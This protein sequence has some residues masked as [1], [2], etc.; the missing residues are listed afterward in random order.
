MLQHEGLTPLLS[1]RNLRKAYPSRSAPPSS[2][3]QV[4]VVKDVNFDVFP[5]ETLG[6]VGESGSGK[7]TIGRA[8]LMLPRPTAGSIKFGDQELT[9][10][11]GDAL[12]DTRRR[13]Q[14][15]FQDPYA[16]LNPRMTIGS[17]IAEPLEIHRILDKPGRAAYV[18]ELLRKVGLQPDAARRY[19]HQFSG[20]QRQRIAIARAIALKPQLIV[21]D[22]PISAL[23]V[24]IQAQI[25]NLMMDL[26]DELKL[27]YLFISHDLRVVR[28]FC[29]RVAVL[30][31]G[32]IVEL[33]ETERLFSDPRHAYTQRLL[34][35]IPVLDPQVERDRSSQR[36]MSQAPEES[37]IGYLTEVEPGH[38]VELPA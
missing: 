28:R 31:Q 4:V 16:A 17:F 3:N 5:N 36:Q 8:V 37:A 14:I 19:P 27:S 25:I 6:L 38:F 33:A 2:G 32:R 15:V 23:D 26:Q 22:E 1:V 9:T 18:A 30:K 7:S 29:H 10:L 11:A 24:S 21:A 13:M 20:G 34:G 35:A 12:R